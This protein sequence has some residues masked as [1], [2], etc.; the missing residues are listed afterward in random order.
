MCFGENLGIRFSDNLT[1]KDLFCPNHGALIIAL[2]DPKIR[3]S[4]RAAAEQFLAAGAW[5]LGATTLD[6]VFV[7]HEETL[8]LA[9]ALAAYQGTL[10][11]IFP[12]KTKSDLQQVDL[13]ILQP[14][15]TGSQIPKTARSTGKIAMSYGSARPRVFIPV[16]PGTNCEYDTAKAFA[17]A[18]A[19][20]D[21][22]IIRNLTASA[23][24]E[25]LHEMEQRIRQ[26]QIIMIPG[27]FSGGDEP[28]GSGKFIASAFRNP[29]VT[30]AIRDLLQHRD[31]LILGI[32][33]GFQALI[34]LGLLP[35]GD[36]ADLSPDSPTLTFNLLGR[37]ISRLI[38][39]RIVSNRSP[40]LSAVRVGDLHTIPVSHGEGRFT[41]SEKW[42]A[43]LTE[44]EQ[45]ATQYVDLSGRPTVDTAFNPNGSV[46]GIEGIVSPDGRIF[47]KMGHSERVGPFLY[48]N[49]PGEKDQQIFASG[50]RYFQ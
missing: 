31:G 17:A 2:A 11:P 45:I 40:W 16:F 46:A 14:P 10:E 6:P 20:P 12:T 23:I 41:A 9:K 47:G 24:S 25:T 21:I 37:H 42:I 19:Q 3:P 48:R 7:Y 38:T 36:I 35:D 22:L 28:E 30:D 44:T 33:N 4:A 32:C 50:V 43:Q 18:G 1:E 29:R 13:P 15:T 8:T 34:K 49:V 26:S 27:G 39:T 5:P